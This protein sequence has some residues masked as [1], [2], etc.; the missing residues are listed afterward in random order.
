M[1]RLFFLGLILSF[2]GGNLLI[3][4]EHWNLD[5]PMLSDAAHA[6]D[7]RPVDLIGPEIDWTPARIEQEIRKV[8]PEVPEQMIQVAKCESKLNP[9][10]KGPTNDHGLFQIHAPSHKS[11]LN[12]VDLYDPIENIAFARKLYEQNRLT[13]WRSSRH[14]WAT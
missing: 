10:A 5:H 7:E 13:P 11:S 4:G 14:C 6:K 8:F 9:N 12:G 3:Y 1:K 2:F